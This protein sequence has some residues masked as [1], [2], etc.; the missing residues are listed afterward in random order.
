MHPCA[1]MSPQSGS[2]WLSRCNAS[3]RQASPILWMIWALPSTGRGEPVLL[4]AVLAAIS[5]VVGAGGG[6]K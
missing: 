3:A 4:A 1:T 6:A 5:T 2:V